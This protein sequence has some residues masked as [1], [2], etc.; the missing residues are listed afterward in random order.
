[1]CLPLFNNSVLIFF[2]GAPVT[3]TL[4][5]TRTPAPRN[6]PS[7]PPVF[8]PLE[9]GLF[10]AGAFI[11]LVLIIT[12]VCV[13]VHVKKRR[14]SMKLPDAK[15]DAVAESVTIEPQS[16]AQRTASVSSTGSAAAFMRQRSIRGRLESRLTQV[17]TGNELVK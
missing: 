15:Y 2:S 7:D 6:A 5:D 10:V 9:T 8:T 17:R 12:I 4:A 1:M 13:C 16:F 11:I 3:T 14:K